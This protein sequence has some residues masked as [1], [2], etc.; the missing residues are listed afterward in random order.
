MVRQLLPPALQRPPLQSRLL[1][2]PAQWQQQQ[3]LQQQALPLA[4]L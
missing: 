1:L 4:L 2:Q 3:L